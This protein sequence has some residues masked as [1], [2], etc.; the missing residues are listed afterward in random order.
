MDNKKGSELLDDT[1][2][3]SL[4][5]QEARI[6]DDAGRVGGSRNP[7]GAPLSDLANAA[8]AT[9]NANASSPTIDSGV[10][11]QTILTGEIGAA[12]GSNLSGSDDITGG[13]A[14]LDAETGAPVEQNEYNR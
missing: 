14:N 7:T 10:L 9:A 13:I 8:G 1:A 4:T 5:K 2:I 3:E 12:G 6:A 11:N